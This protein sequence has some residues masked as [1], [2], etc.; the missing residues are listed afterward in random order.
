MRSFAEYRKIEFKSKVYTSTIKESI[1]CFLESLRLDLLEK[2]KLPQML[3][4][5]NL[6]LNTIYNHSVKE[7]YQKNKTL[8]QVLKKRP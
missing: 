1:S 3:L 7:D 4:E 2:V 5:A 6:A 8:F